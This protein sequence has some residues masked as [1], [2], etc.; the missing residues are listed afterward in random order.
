VTSEPAGARLVTTA[1]AGTAAFVLT[2][3]GGVVVPDAFE[4]AV[5]VV[6]LVLFAIGCVAFLWAYAV[7]V[8]RSRRETIGIA[9]LF[10]LQGSAPRDVRRRLL[11][12][13]A[14]QVVV[15]FAAASIRPFTGVAFGILVPVFGIGMCGLWG[16]RYGTF[17]PRAEPADQD[18]LER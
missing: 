8:S 3:L 14:V 11:G 1:L 17:T 10:F 13:L 4:L 12:A 7:A 18:E 6:S 16:A 15:A 5:V 9:A 2:A